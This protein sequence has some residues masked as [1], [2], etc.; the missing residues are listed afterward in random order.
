V[1]QGHETGRGGHP[2][3]GGQELADADW[4]AE[5]L[6]SGLEA[7]A[8]EN[9]LKLCKAQAPVRVALTGRTV[10]LPLFEAVECWAASAR[11]PA[12]TPRQRSWPQRTSAPLIGVSLMCH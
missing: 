10:G 5:A 4:T 6:R 11:W 1:G 8:A 2:R 12:S 7:A 3:V 9:G